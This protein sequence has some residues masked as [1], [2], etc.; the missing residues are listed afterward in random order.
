MTSHKPSETRDAY[1][2]VDFNLG[3]HVR[4]Y[5]LDLT[6][7]VRPNRLE[8]TASLSVVAE[9]DLTAMTLDLTGRLSVRRVKAPVRVARF[10]HS[11]NKLRL[12]FADVVPAGTEFTL[13]IRYGGNPGPRRTAWGE[14][15]WEELTDGSLVAS[16]PNG[17]AT[18]FPCDDTPSRK[19]TYDVRVTADDPY[20][21]VVN[22]ELL[23]R[24]ARGSATTWHYQAELPV[25]SYLMTVQTGDYQRFELGARTHAWAPPALEADVHQ[26]FARQEEMLELF[27]ATFGDYPYQSYGVVIAEDELE[28]PLEAH[29]LSTF[30]INHLDPEWERLLAHEV[31]HQWFGNSL[32]LKRWSDIWLNEGFACY[33]EWLWA[34]HAHGIPV[35]DSVREHYDGLAGKPQDIV[36][37]DPGPKDMFDDRV[38]KRGAI[39]LHA[40]RVSLGDE[41][42][43]AAVRRY[44]AAGR[45]NLVEPADLRAELGDVDVVWDAWLNEAALPE[46]PQ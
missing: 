36:I 41:A 35:A 5:E 23:E 46:Y 14:I 28:I 9:D 19:S 11:G 26:A 43:F 2:G 7:R 40:L 44:V 30:G 24:V 12:T 25:A 1:T 17:A 15:G 31:A 34:E 18:W 27:E 33:C 45:H 42:F 3:F 4:H 8:G 16:Q 21:V 29:G 37:G 39:T 6:Y 38:Y 22:G 10:K 13:E 20:Y 32:G